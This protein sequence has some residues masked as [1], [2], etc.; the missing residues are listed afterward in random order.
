MKTGNK[1]YY[2]N[3]ITMLS[4]NTLSQMIPFLIAPVLARIFSPVDFAVVANFMAIVGVIG[5]VATGRLELAIPLPKD[6]LK[7]QEIVFTGLMITLVL[8]GLSVFIPLF[9]KQVGALYKDQIL[10]EF[11]WLVPLSVISYGLLGSANNWSLRHEKFKSISIGKIGQSL[12]NNGLA[13]ILGYIGWGINGLIIAWLISQYINI[14]ILLI[15]VKSKVNRKDFGIITIKSTLKEYKDFPLINS[16]HAF[17]DI[18][19]TQFLLFWLISTYFGYFEL[20]L[21]AMMN[22]YVRA[23]IVLISSSVSQL[24]YIEAGKAINNG[25]S[26]VP[27]LTKTIKTSFL[28]A[29]PFILILFL[30]GPII[31]KWYLG[32][33]W[34]Q[35]GAYAQSITPMLFLSFIVSPI[36]GLPIILNKQR[37]AFLFSVF[38]YS[39]SLLALL[40]ALYYN[41]DFKNSL[42]FYS[43]AFCVY[44]VLVLFWYFKLIK[45]NNEGIN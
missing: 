10:P 4:G 39:L 24:F 40:I 9:S 42:W 32:A 6:H 25:T 31:F 30:F 17:T 41:F 21:F 34:E 11:L 12:V 27:I 28:F 26:L 2:R 3:F 37:G 36:S 29:I 1:V 20:G 38:G 33:E 7:A 43:G 35:A 23:P 45:K 13:A 19:V 16:L 44:Y 18:F 14:L 8:G 15:G 22:K 5:I